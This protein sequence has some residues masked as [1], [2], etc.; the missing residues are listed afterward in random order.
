MKSLA[1][2]TGMILCC[3][4]TAWSQAERSVFSP[5]GDQDQVQQLLIQWTL[6]EWQ[7][8]A[9][10]ARGN[11]FTEGFHQSFLQVDRE[12]NPA[13]FSDLEIKVAPNPVHQ[14]LT[15]NARAGESYPLHLDLY[16]LSGKHLLM[17]LKMDSNG[18]SLIDVSH[19]AASTYILT[20]RNER[21][22]PEQ[23]F[24]VLKAR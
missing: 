21:G 7:V 24:K 9:H 6:G 13:L 14:F 3:V 8:A 23:N 15:V 12:Y 19:L 11:L 20:V 10:E 22:E 18:S 1:F 5:A 17:Q 16:D 4:C 2:L